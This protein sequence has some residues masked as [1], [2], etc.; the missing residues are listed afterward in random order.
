MKHW[1]AGIGVVGAAVLLV[2]ALAGVARTQGDGEP[3]LG[4]AVVVTPGPSSTRPDR[5]DPTTTTVRDGGTP[6]EPSA[7]PRGGGDDDDDG[8]DDGDD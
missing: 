5:P 6:V 3:A 7:P 4:P 1:K 8:G 2:V